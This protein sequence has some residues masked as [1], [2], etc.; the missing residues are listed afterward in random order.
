MPVAPDDPRLQQCG[1]AKLVDEANSLDYVMRKY[2]IVLGRHS[3]S[4]GTDVVLG[5][6]NMNVS[7]AHAKIRWNFDSRCFELLVMGKN[8][9]TIRGSL[10]T[11]ASAP[12]PLQSQDVLQ[13]G[14]FNITF[15]L[16]RAPPRALARPAGAAPAAEHRPQAQPAWN[17]HLA[18][19]GGWRARR[20]GCAA[21]ALRERR[22]RA[23]LA[24]GGR[25][26]P[27]APLQARR[28]AP[29]R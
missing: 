19:H 1:F 6:E 28:W 14:T 4:A 12:F 17:G 24:P 25:R 11:P 13:I 22:W 29:S 10:V 18:H 21:A 27:T 9:V 20:A 5:Q 26:G 15:L 16:P 8:G 23:R 2:E 3:K 7:R